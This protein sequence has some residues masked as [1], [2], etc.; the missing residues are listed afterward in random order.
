MLVVPP[1]ALAAPQT[2]P[3]GGRGLR[4]P[5]AVAQSAAMNPLRG[6]LPELGVR[7]GREAGALC[8]SLVETRWPRIR[9]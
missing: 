8:G 2:L 6:F 1:P 4:P 5:G 3:G 7:A 9:G